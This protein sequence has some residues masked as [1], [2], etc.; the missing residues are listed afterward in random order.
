MHVLYL[1]VSCIKHTLSPTGSRMNSAINVVRLAPERQAKLLL[2]WV[3]SGWQ[4]IV[5]EEVWM[6]RQLLSPAAMT[7]N[8]KLSYRLEMNPSPKALLQAPGLVSADISFPI[9][10]KSLISATGE[11]W[12]HCCTGRRGE[13][14]EHIGKNACCW[15]PSAFAARNSWKNCNYNGILKKKISFFF[16]LLIKCQGQLKSGWWWFLWSSWNR[17]IIIWRA[18]ICLP[19]PKSIL[20]PC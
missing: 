5:R 9:V 18:P 10:K 1:Q 11:F 6:S 19:V 13:D 3:S 2:T 20:Y 14:R 4:W 8:R 12:G 7:V 15:P 17:N 16:F